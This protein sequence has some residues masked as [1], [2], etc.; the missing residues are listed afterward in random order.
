MLVKTHDTE[1]FE[2][3]LKKC[4]GAIHV[5]AHNGGERDW[6]INKGFK[7]VIWF[8]PNIQVFEELINNLKEFPNQTAYNIGIYDENKSAIL[9]I[10]SNRGESSSILELGLHKKYYPTVRYIRD[11]KIKLVRMDNFIDSKKINIDEFN[12]LNIDVQGV[13][14]NVIKSFDY[15]ILKMDYIYV[16][17]NEA[18]LYVGCSLISDIDEYLKPYGFKR[19]FTY[20]TGKQWGDALYVHKRILS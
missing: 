12:F 9:H 16:E 4:R 10:S 19:M 8:E 11:E 17:V 18:E 13:E 5:G 7:Q 3:H 14:L 6:Y 15:W 20:M 1:N 2:Q